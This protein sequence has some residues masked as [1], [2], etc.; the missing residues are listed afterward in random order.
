MK[1]KKIVYRVHSGPYNKHHSFA[2]AWLCANAANPKSW[3]Y[4]NH[5]FTSG[6]TDFETEQA[7]K[8]A[9]AK[10]TNPEKHRVAYF[11]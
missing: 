2:G 5:P 7:A 1:T 4:A 8:D 6:V 10:T 11:K 9:I 3:N